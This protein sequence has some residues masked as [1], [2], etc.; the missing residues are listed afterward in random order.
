[1][2]AKGLSCTGPLIHWTTLANVSIN[3]I[4]PL[5]KGGLGR[6]HARVEALES[7]GKTCKS[8]LNVRLS[9]R[10]ITTRDLL[11][12]PENTTEM[13]YLNR[14]NLQESKIR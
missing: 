14:I 3:I 12:M 1:M 13:Q 11:Y 4:E 10:K 2:A 5:G 6:N 9:G 8:N 7:R